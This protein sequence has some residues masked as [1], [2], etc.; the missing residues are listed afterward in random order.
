MR[1]GLR[2]SPPS[3]DVPAEVDWLLLRAL[4]REF[5]AWDETGTLDPKGLSELA[6]AVGLLGRVRARWPREKLVPELGA[7]LLEEA[8]RA[9]HRIAANELLQERVSSQIAGMASEEGEPSIFL[10]GL[11]LRLG[12]HSIAGARQASDIDVLVPRDAAESLSRTLIQE[13]STKLEI[14]PQEH[15]LPPLDHPLGAVVEIHV[16]LR[17]VNLEGRGAA[18]AEECISSGQC[19]AL[20]GWPEGTYIPDSSLLMAHLLVHGLGQHG[21]SPGAYPLIQLLADLQDLGFTGE[22]GE[23]F[24]EEGLLW[25][26]NE[27]SQEEV[28][29]TRD[30]LRQLEEGER[31]SEIVVRDVA[32]ALILKH[33][34]AGSMDAEYRQSLKLSA[35]TRPSI[36]RPGLTGLLRNMSSAIFLTRGQI[37][38]IYGQ[39]QTEVGYLARRLWRPFDLVGRTLKTLQAKKKL[40]FRE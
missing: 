1:Q 13:G 34:L 6:G 29:G 35:V 2:F 25:I 32:A 39:P 26:Q 18:T 3:I 24:M 21:F 19:R 11:A 4:G 37:D 33:M 14:Q 8:D 9:I 12:G 40:R 22:Q 38:V 17:G 16:D 28:A 10:K 30:L 5:T 7:G 23:R 27:V 15:H 31:A 36:A 20:E